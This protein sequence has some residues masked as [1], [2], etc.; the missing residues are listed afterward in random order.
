MS[1]K[2]PF[3]EANL[4]AL[5]AAVVGSIG[6]L[7]ALGLVPAIVARNP[8]FLAATPTMN[9]ICFFLCGVMGWF[10]GGQLGPR[11]HGLFGEKHGHIVGGV[12]GGL[13]PVLG[14]AAIGWYLTTQPA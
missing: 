2:P 5:I 4:A 10:L 7:F 1:H 3:G 14:I 12:I 13:L 9:V 6:G 11:L 8:Q